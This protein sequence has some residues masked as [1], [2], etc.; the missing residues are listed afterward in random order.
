VH[1]M[2]KNGFR[3]FPLLAGIMAA[4]T[5]LTGAWIITVSE[6][7]RQAQSE[8]LHVLHK[9]GT[10]RARLEG[11]LTAKVLLL[12][13]IVSYVSINGNIDHETFQSF[14]EGL[15]AGDHIIRNV[16]LLK[17]TKIVEVFPTKGQEKAL[18]IDLA[19]VPEQRN[20]LLKAIET[21]EPV[22]AGPVSLV[23]GGVGIITRIPIFLTSKG[24]PLGE[25]PYWGQTSVVIMQ[26]N[27]FE[28]I[29]IID[30]SSGLKYSLRGKD[31]LGAKG[32]V[33]W[34]DDT[35]FQSDPITLDVTLPG[36]TWQMAAIPVSGWASTS[37]SLFGIYALGGLLSIFA[38]WMTCSLVSAKDKLK[39][40][41]TIERVLLERAKESEKKYK[42]LFD[43]S[44]D[45]IYTHDSQGNCTSV[46]AAVTRI[47]GYT[48]DEAMRLNL[49]QV[50]HPD[51]LSTVQDR[52]QEKLDKIVERNGPYEIAARAK[53]GRLVWLEITNRLIKQEGRVAGVHGTARDITTRKEAEAE[54]SRLVTAI[55]QA[56]DII[57]I[58]EPSGRI[59]YVN[60]AFESTTGYTS[61]EAMGNNPRILKSGTQDKA[62]YKEMWNTIARGEVWRGRFTNKRKD[63]T[64]YEE[65][66]TV[67][68]VKDSM[69]QVINYV[70]VKRDVT[71]ELI[72][73]KQLLQAQKMEAIGTLAGG[74]AHDFNNL[75]QAILG[76]ADLLLMR[77]APGDPD[78][79]KIEIIY[80]AARDGADL[81][82]RI[83]TFS[84]RLE[85]NTR[86]TDLNVQ[87]RRVEKLMRRTVPK[88]IDIELILAD[89]LRIIDA[90]P[91]QIEQILLNLAV[92]AQ[93]A[94]PDG[95]ELLIETSN[96]SL[97]DEYLRTHLRAKPGEY[98]R[99]TVSDTGIGMAA[100]VHD[101]I[102]E[103]FFTTKTNE[104][105]TGLGLAMVHGI[106][107]QHEGSIE[108]YS[109]P[110]IGTSFK[111]YWPVSKTDRPW[112]LAEP[113]E[114]PAFGNETILL[115]EDDEPIREIGK[116]MIEIGGYRVLLAS[117]GEEALKIYANHKEDID[118]VIL[119]LIMPGMGGTKCFEELLKI[120]PNVKI[121]VAS[122]Y[123]SNISAVDT[124]LEVARGFVGKPYDA[125]DVLGAIRKVLDM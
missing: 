15:V 4:L 63:G 92:N 93:H 8:R 29:G 14:A 66:A 107:S 37:N 81:V 30:S 59:L 7:Q 41:L 73:Q 42:D 53:D 105:G 6:Q 88:M 32:P 20:T 120:N 13:S 84:R 48:I 117:T 124:K 18:G 51:Y 16:T 11:A 5:V 104:E 86:P 65:T 62:F 74:I 97:Q 87:I 103:P 96:V 98:V 108:C 17:D 69:G 54:R 39:N 72:L 23:Q 12:K 111:I 125:K 115:V 57:V 106:V 40:Q 109:E 67:S 24:K 28:Q 1:L 101:R 10:V 35:V 27:L 46:N 38:G 90:D 114:M 64:L 58:T 3:P 55:E 123:S 89:D 118:L 99:L 70:A 76:Y 85:A 50:I 36:G 61:E 122:G 121:L 26:E 110:G 9:M 44:T 19:L 94:M 68:P 60:P 47:L 80:R 83:L 2:G 21:K 43:N 71:A 34:G 113:R 112:E 33:F 95:G 75:L 116:Q 119:D 56:G 52:F 91:A 102:F 22:V 31:G 78:R 79:H 82:S 45:L 49:R 25:G 100:E 77:K